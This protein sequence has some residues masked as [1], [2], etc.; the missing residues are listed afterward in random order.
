MESVST[1]GKLLTYVYIE[2]IESI[3]ILHFFP[4]RVEVCSELPKRIKAYY[5]VK[6]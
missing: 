1:T 6:R 2:L 3:G 4:D 5:I